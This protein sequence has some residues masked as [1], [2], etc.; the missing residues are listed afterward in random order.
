[1][2]PIIVDTNNFDEEVINVADMKVLVDFWGNHCG[3]CKVMDPIIYQIAEEME[4]IKVCKCNIDENKELAK[5]YSVLSKP[6]FLVFIN[7]EEKKYA[8]GARPKK[9][10]IKMIEEL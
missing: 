7:G 8:V 5:K 6:T 3:P 10:M 4:D 2:K 9:D 1:M